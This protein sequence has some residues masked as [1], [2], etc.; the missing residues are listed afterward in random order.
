[1][2]YS[3]EVLGETME[4]LLISSAPNDRFLGILSIN[5]NLVKELSD[6]LGDGESMEFEPLR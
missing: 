3:H 1:M 4:L 6:S 2:L 5:F